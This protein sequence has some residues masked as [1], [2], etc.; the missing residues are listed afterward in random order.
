MLNFNGKLGGDVSG[1]FR[2]PG[3]HHVNQ[4]VIKNFVLGTLFFK[5]G[6]SKRHKH[7]GWSLLFK[8]VAV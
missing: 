7:G 5:N 1:T 2:L 6:D 3:C 4:E 8:I